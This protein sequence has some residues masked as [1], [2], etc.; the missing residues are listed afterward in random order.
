MEELLIFLD[1]KSRNPDLQLV[2]VVIDVTPDQLC[3]ASEQLYSHWPQE[4][5][6]PN[7]STKKTWAEALEKITSFTMLRDDQVI[8]VRQAPLNSLCSMFHL[9]SHRLHKVFPATVQCNLQHVIGQS[10]CSRTDLAV[11]EVKLASALLIYNSQLPRSTLHRPC[12]VKRHKVI[13]RHLPS[14]SHFNNKRLALH[15]CVD[16]AS[17]CKKAYI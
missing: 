4:Y 17:L 15:I 10:I 6:E 13:V 7:E 3:S 12:G 11:G 14:T 8:A 5:E 9:H 16:D 1:Q 2:P